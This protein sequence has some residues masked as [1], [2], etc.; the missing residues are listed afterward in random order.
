MIP[1]RDCG[2]TDLMANEVC[3]TCQ[4]KRYIEPVKCPHRDCGDWDRCWKRERTVIPVPIEVTVMNTLAGWF[5][6]GT[7]LLGLL[8]LAIF[9]L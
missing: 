8:G 3:S 4:G 6:L 7:I 5:L 2:A 9:L 1:C